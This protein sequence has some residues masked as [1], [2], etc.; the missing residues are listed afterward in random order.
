MASHMIVERSHPHQAQEASFERFGGLCAM[1]AGVGGLLYAI[2]FVIVARSAPALGAFLSALLLTCNGLLASSVMAALY[3][4]L[5]SVNPAAA[6]WALVLGSVGAI[7]ATIHGGYDL[8]NAFHPP[9]GLSTELPSQI[10]PRGL[11]TFG[12]SG[13]A[14]LIN[15][16]LIRRDSTFPRG[17]GLLTTLLGALLL[18]I[19][20]AR[21]IILSPADPILLVPVLLTGFLVN[22]AWYFWLGRRLLRQSSVASIPN[23]L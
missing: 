3:Q 13:I 4:R 10:D 2:A 11:L 20:L 1:L 5:R 22:P 12:I 7:G 21:L 15:A 6:L 16:W 14:L 18:L 23:T 8:A 9:A 19:Y 17:L